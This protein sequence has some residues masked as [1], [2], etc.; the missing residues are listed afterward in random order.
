MQ[1]PIPIQ[2]VETMIGNGLFNGRLF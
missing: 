1:H 2:L